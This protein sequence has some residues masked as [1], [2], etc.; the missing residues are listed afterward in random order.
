MLAYSSSR[1]VVGVRGSSPN[2]ML[3]IITAHV[4]ALAVLMSAKMDLPKL[5]TDPPIVV[6]TIQPNPPEPVE[7]QARPDPA[8]RPDPS[9]TYKDPV[10]PLPADPS[11]GVTADPLPQLR[12]LANPAPSAN[13]GTVITKPIA[14]TPALLLTGAAELKPPYPASKLASGEEADLKLR[15][16]IDASGR[17]VA[18]E[19]VGRADAAFLA[20]ARRH[21]RAHW[22]YR[23]AMSEGHGVATTLVISLR[24]RL[25]D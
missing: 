22:R 1:P 17:V 12:G 23:P 14:A 24:F 6:R 5:I 2:S 4:A 3:F 16:T 9:L 7:P 8:P 15:L 10:V 18:V 21:I 11:P 19:P 13:F 20:E 25:D